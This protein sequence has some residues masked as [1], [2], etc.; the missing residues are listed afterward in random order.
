M[1]VPWRRTPG[2]HVGSHHEPSDPAPGR[3]KSGSLRTSAARVFRHLSR[4]QGCKLGRVELALA[5][6]RL[7][8]AA[9]RKGLSKAFPSR[10]R[11]IWAVMAR[12]EPS[13]LS[14]APAP[15]AHETNPGQRRVQNLAGFAGP[16]TCTGGC[17]KQWHKPW[18]PFRFGCPPDASC[19]AT[20]TSG[21]CLSG[22][23]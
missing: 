3:A 4:Y 19:R 18:Q 12:C 2:Q 22:G 14:R 17:S 20:V 5:R 8:I 10:Y 16:R 6:P 13:R 1:P 21:M 9:R 7:P 23:C 11:A 15:P